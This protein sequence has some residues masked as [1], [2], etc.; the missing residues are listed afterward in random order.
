MGVTRDPIIPENS[1]LKIYLQPIEK[2]DSNILN[3]AISHVK[4]MYIALFEMFLL[5]D[6]YLRLTVVVSRLVLSFQDGCSLVL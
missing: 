3:S 6:W 1:H 5:L 2:F 4:A